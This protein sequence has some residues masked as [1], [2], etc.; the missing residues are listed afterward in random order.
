MTDKMKRAMRVGTQGWKQFLTAKKTMLDAYD[1]AKEQA[2]AHEV[3]I[4]HGNVAEAEF[5]SWLSEFLPKRYG[6]TPGYI[7]SQGLKDD[8]QAPHFDV[9]IYDALESPIL[10]VEDNRDRSHKGTSRAIPAEHVR[11]VIEVKSSLTPASAAHAMEHLRDLES[12]LKDL[13]APN[14]RYKKFLPPSFF[15]GIVFFELCR[16]HEFEKEMINKLV[17][18]RDIRGYSGGIVLRGEG[19]QPQKSGRIWLLASKS[20]IKSTVG[21]KRES[22]LTGSPL[23]DTRRE[24]DNYHRGMML[25]WS[26]AEFARFAFDLVALLNNTYDRRLS[27]F[28]GMSWQSTQKDDSPPS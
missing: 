21:K 16:K 27:S 28:H 14:E 5:R 25:Q 4:E 23:S 15:S 12:L 1:R 26:E 11:S 2:S 9:V 19:L 7:I 24:F 8:S 22:L 18:E 20:S 3:Q 17:P 6:V 13:D 10:W